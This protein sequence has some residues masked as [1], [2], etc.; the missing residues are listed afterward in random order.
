MIKLDA[1]REFREIFDESGIS[2]VFLDYLKRMGIVVSVVFTLTAVSSAVIHNLIFKLSLPKMVLV[3]LS[4][5]L[6]TADLATFLYLVYPLY[7]R[8]QN[9]NKI[10]SNLIYTL[11]YMDILSAGGASIESIM[12][13]VSDVEEN[14]QIRQLA[15]KFVFDIQ[16]L[17]FDVVTTLE[18]VS[19]RT[20]SGALKRLLESIIHNIR[21]SGDLRSLFSYE[22]KGLF[23]SKR[24]GLKSMMR[25]MNYLGEMYVALMVVGPILFILMISILS[26]FSG[27]T[28]SAVQLNL[29]VFFGMPVLAAVFIIILDTVLEG[30]D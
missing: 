25:S 7:R 4:I 26:I 6:V 27:S 30:D 16:L 28:S 13:R 15:R 24:E 19:K 10:E 17:G 3:V 12:G 9:R 22:I 2:I 29:I 21:M 14:P 5:S 1:I 20:P 18:D 23:K 8:N 11:S